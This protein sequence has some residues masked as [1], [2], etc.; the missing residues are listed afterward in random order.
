MIDLVEYARLAGAGRIIEDQHD[1][2]NYDAEPDAVAAWME[3][4]LG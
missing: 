2:D 1:D 3:T 4:E